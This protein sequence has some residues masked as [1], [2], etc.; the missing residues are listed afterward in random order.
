M[1]TRLALSLVGCG[2][3]SFGHIRPLSLHAADDAVLEPSVA[4]CGK[5][6]SPDTC[7]ADS[8]IT[9]GQFAAP[10]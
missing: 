3:E 1:A 10:L 6:P 5:I 9:Y 4:G 2:A 8:E 7:T